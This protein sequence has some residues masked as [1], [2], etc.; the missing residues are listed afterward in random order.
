LD[1]VVDIS[2][3]CAS[4]DATGYLLVCSTQ[5]SSAVVRRL[6]EIQT[7]KGIVTRYW[8]SIEVEKRLN[9]PNTFPLINI[10][11]PKSSA[12]TRWRIYNTTRP[13]FWAAN[14]K[15][16]FLYLGSRISNLYPS[17]P[18]VEEIVKRLESVELPKGSDWNEHFIRPRAVYFDDKHD[19]YTV[20]AD[21][22]YPR[23]DNRN[24]LLPTQLD[25]VLKDGQGLYSDAQAMW[26]LTHWDISY[27]STNQVSDHFHLDH[28]SYY[29]PYMDNFQTG[30]ARKS[31]I[32]KLDRVRD[33]DLIAVR[34]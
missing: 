12:G 13:S 25:R 24:V 30:S 20:F 33:P 32:N 16:Y 1:D 10:F 15:D 22:I 26:K 11:F 17:L 19:Q 29:E 8:D 5:P 21:Y 23:G 34:G 28:K 2:D 31:F 6:Q 27:V 14:Y 7:N 3:A 9:A 18:D 4:V